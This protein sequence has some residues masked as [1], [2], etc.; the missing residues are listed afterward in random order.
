MCNSA[1]SLPIR[2]LAMRVARRPSTCPSASTTN[3][4]FPTV[5][6]SASRPFGTYVRISS[7][8]L[9]VLRQ[10]L[11]IA[12]TA[13]PVKRTLRDA[14]ASFQTRCAA[15]SQQRGPES[16]PT[17]WCRAPQRS[18]MRVTSRQIAQGHHIY[19]YLQITEANPVNKIPKVL[20][21]SR[22]SA[23]RSQIAEGFLRSL[24]GDRFIPV[25]AGA[26]ATGVS[27]L[28]A[29]VM[30]EVGLVFPLRNRAR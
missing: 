3:Q 26:D 23:S 14:V 8:Y 24:A 5:R 13:F 20:F 2:S 16:N 11:T 1:L 6:S 9:S 10:T 15:A 18:V 19:R 27:P 7:V 28:A 22:G 25:S 21:F 4:F 17:T 12:Y 30:R 29:E